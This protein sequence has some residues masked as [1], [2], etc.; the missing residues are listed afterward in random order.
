MSESLPKTVRV[1]EY[2]AITIFITNTMHR[3]HSISASLLS[4]KVIEREDDRVRAT[5]DC[6]LLGERDWWWS[7]R[8]GKCCYQLGMLR[9]AEAH[10]RSSLAQQTMIISSLELAKIDIKRDQPN[11][12]LATYDA[13]LSAI[14]GDID[15]LLGKARIYDMLN[16]QAAASAAFR[17]VLRMDGS[18]IEALACR[19]AM[20]YHNDEP[21][22]ALRLYRRLLQMGVG[23]AE[24][25]NNIGLCSLAMSQYDITLH[26]FQQA[27]RMSTDATATDIWYNIGKHLSIC[28]NGVRRRCGYRTRLADRG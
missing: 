18:N 28:A 25:W 22:M 15:A 20:H 5:V 3:R 1:L 8:C 10:F 12:A 6:L 11:G 21:Q 23:H 13:C 16:D 14:P 17:E 26:C 7:A 19:A 27:L 24:I 4:K 9:E 2:C